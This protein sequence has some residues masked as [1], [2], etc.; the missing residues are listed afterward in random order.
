MPNAPALSVTS[1]RVS[2]SIRWVEKTW[3]DLC[4]LAAE[5][6]VSR[7]DMANILVKEALEAREQRKAES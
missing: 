3:D 7:N 5:W 2:V 4:D 6:G 1:D